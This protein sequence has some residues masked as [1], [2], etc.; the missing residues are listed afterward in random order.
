MTD[1]LREEAKRVLREGI[2]E[3]VIGWAEGSAEFKT[4]P[5]FAFTE[6]DCDRLVWNTA[7]VNN[8]A[9]YLTDYPKEKKIALCVKPC[10]SAS[11]NVLI[12]ENKV[13][14]EN[15][16]VIGLAC[17]GVIDPIKAADAGTCELSDATAKYACL[18]C[19]HD[20]P[21]VADIVLGEAERK[22]T[23]AGEDM[24]PFEE[25]RKYWEKEFDTCVRC[26]ACRQVCPNCYC[27]Q[28]F[29]DRTD[30]KWTSRK[31]TAGESWMFH[32]V[33]VMHMAGRCVGCGECERVCPKSIPVEK[34]SREMAKYVK[35]IYDYT[36]GM[37]EKPLLGTY[38]DE[39]YDA[40]VHEE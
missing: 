7:C 14:R 15:V 2:A 38:K 22:L 6:E 13:L 16:Y 26:Y 33:R 1:K 5:F 21:E 29:A 23:P 34:L 24:P 30:P 11:V 28:C 12:A 36:A 19:V 32:A 39:D 31:P 8:L 40:G 35:D 20:K 37:G 17:G 3:M 27:E 9:K 10:D 4:T 25:R 18:H